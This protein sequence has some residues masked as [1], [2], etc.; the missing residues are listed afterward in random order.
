MQYRSLFIL[1]RQ[2]KLSL[3]EL[4]S[5]FGA[6][7]IIP[8]GEHAISTLP[9]NNIPFS[10][11]GGT[12]KTANILAELDHANWIKIEKF[13]IKNVPIHVENLEPGKFTL[14]LSVY[15]INMTPD[16]INKTALKIKKSLKPS[17]RSVR[18]IP[19]KSSE[20]NSA[21][22]LHNKLTYKNGWELIV[23][24]DGQKTYIAQTIFV[25]DIDDYSIRD[26]QRPK[27]D[28]VVGMLPPKLAQ[29]LINLCT[30][31]NKLVESIYDPF[32][33]T[34]VVL[35]EAMLM[36]YKAIGSDI[37]QKMID[38]SDQNLKWLKS[39]PKYSVTQNYELKQIDAQNGNLLSSDFVA[40]EAYL[41]PVLRGRSDLESINKAIKEVNPI[42]EGFLKN[43]YSHDIKNI[44]LAVP[45]WSHSDSFI[46]LPVI[47]QIT[48]LG[49]NLMSFAHASPEEMVYYRPDQAVA[50]KIIVLT[51]R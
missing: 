11:L 32:C 24:S 16:S 41:G 7:F 3:A 14:G 30:A 51:K 21:Q 33:G 18:I 27:R 40:S 4:E 26:R 44:C 19:N 48:D 22:V 6:D 31:Q 2:P 10:R 47:D 17:G 25:Q 36:G 12:L 50:R 15:G 39:H 49:Y 38:Y 46:N 13:L 43:A 20:L 37:S 35:Q 42:I 28:S 34:G 29:I 1:G 5:L 8:W 9:A 45:C 23:I